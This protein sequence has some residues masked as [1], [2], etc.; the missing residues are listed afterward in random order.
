MNKRSF[1]FATLASVTLGA[2]AAYCVLLEAEL[3]N[4]PSELV[5]AELCPK[6]DDHIEG[7]TSDGEFMNYTFPPAYINAKF[8]W[9]RRHR[10]TPLHLE[11]SIEY[12]PRSGRPCYIIGARVNGLPITEA[13]KLMEQNAFPL[14]TT[15]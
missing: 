4:T 6:C 9:R 7:S 15:P 1:L 2:Q 14:T 10:D 12:I 8:D 5:A 13:V 3:R 11:Y